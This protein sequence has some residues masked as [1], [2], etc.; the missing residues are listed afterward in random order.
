M[1]R[2]IA[3]G[4]LLFAAKGIG[5]LQPIDL[6]FSLAGSSLAVAGWLVA[7]GVSPVSEEQRRLL[8]T[9]DLTAIDR[10]LVFPDDPLL[11]G[12]SDLV[13]YGQTLAP[14]GIVALGMERQDARE[15]LARHF[16]VLAIT[17]GSA[18]LLKAA[19]WRARPFLYFPDVTPLRAADPAGANSFPSSHVAISFASAAFISTVANKYWN[20]RY[21][22]LIVVGS[23]AIAS[24]SAV[25]R[26]A[27]G[28][29][30]VSDVLA[31]A[32][33]G[34]V[35]GWIVPTVHASLAR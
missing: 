31:G 15:L 17:Y 34:M 6:T 18:Y 9:A 26:V 2:L 29:H 30:F 10:G 35:V 5:A 27:A 8:R 11:S 20:E 23:Y 33:L 3:F 32:L 19:V 22:K 24:L 1:R 14:V 4:L 12:I 25:L 16:L 28:H 21:T 13:A 7:D